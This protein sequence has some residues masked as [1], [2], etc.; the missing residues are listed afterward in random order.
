MNVSVR[1][2]LYKNIFNHLYSLGFRAIPLA[3]AQNMIGDGD[4]ENLL[5]K[6]EEYIDYFE[7]LLQN[8]DLKKAGKMT[9][10][11][12]GLEKIEYSCERNEGCGAGRYMRAI[13]I[14]GTMYPCHRFVGNA[15]YALGSIFTGEETNPESNELIFSKKE[16]CSS[17]WC[18]NLCLGGCH[19][20]NAAAS[21]NSE[22]SIRI[23]RDNTLITEH[24]IRDNKEG[25]FSILK[26]DIYTLVTSQKEQL[27]NTQ[28]QR[29]VLAEYMSDISHQL[30][31]PIT[32]MEI[33]IDLLENAAPEKQAEFIYNIKLM[34]GKMEWLVKNLLNMAKI[35]AGTINFSRE[36][37]KVSQLMENVLPSVSILL[38][39]NEQ[40]IDILNDTV[41]ECDKRWTV[42][43]LTN[44]VKNAIEHSPHNTKI[45][46][47]CGE[48]SI[49]RWISVRDHGT[50]IDIATYSAMFQRF[51]YSTNEAGFGIGLPLALSII[52]GQGGDIDLEIPLKGNGSIFMMKFFK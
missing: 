33:M 44:I 40:Q 32:S 48:N 7:E 49:Y 31:T 39:I 29:D 17:C 15:K 19:Y 51:Q 10:L 3:V 42:E 9:D 43:A 13:D 11:I 6:Y 45:E 8:K 21:D 27:K 41:M 26:N 2:S 35:D 16:K 4:F 24:D 52:K 50:G 46:I 20:E 36:K 38:D 22:I 18:R 30:K 23:L 47:D 28:K 25:A 1:S 14:N 34:L 5:Q 37:I 12:N